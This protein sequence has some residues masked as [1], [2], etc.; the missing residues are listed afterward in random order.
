M[1][2]NEGEYNWQVWHKNGTRCPEGSIPIRRVDDRLNGKSGSNSG[3]RTP[4]GMMYVQTYLVF[5]VTV[6]C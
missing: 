6:I 2:K 3:N 5:V 1:V 4:K